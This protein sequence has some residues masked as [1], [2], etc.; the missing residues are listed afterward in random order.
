M[1]E[2]RGVRKVV[3]MREITDVQE[4]RVTSGESGEKGVR[5]TTCMV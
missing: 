1:R 3:G 2:M 5:R 4:G